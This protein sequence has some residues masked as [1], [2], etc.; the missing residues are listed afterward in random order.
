MTCNVVASALAGFRRC[1]QTADGARIATHCLYPSSE[2]VHVYV[3]KM[4]D[5]FLVHDGG[6]SF[7]VAWSHG[8]DE[9]VINKALERAAERF[10]VHAIGHQL[11]IKDIPPDWLISAILAIANAAS[12]AAF[13]AVERMNASNEIALVKQIDSFLSERFTHNQ[14]ARELTL[15]G[16]SGGKRRF[17]FAIRRD[18]N[19]DFLINAITP[20][21]ASIAAKYVAFSDSAM[22]REKKLAVFGK[23]LDTDDTAL[24]KEV[25]DVLPLTAL[26]SEIVRAVAH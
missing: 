24:L 14:I 6:D 19:Y 21:H 12:Q 18:G 9:P 2:S 23:P 26:G 7:R 17:D 3:V 10:H 20:H 11:R 4:G 1:E 5:T 22:P 8:R 13:A 15:T 16:K 25:A